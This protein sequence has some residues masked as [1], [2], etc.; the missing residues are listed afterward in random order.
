MEYYYSSRVLLAILVV[1]FLVSGAS[2]RSVNKTDHEVVG[3]GRGGR[4]WLGMG[5]IPLM[6]LRGSP[7]HIPPSPGD[8][9][10]HPPGH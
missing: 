9:G 8:N 5:Y 6:I 3:F 7:S 4:S 1:G 10:H 2:A